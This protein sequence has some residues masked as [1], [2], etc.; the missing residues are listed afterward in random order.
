M[1]RRVAILR[2]FVINPDVLLMDEPFV[3][4]DPPTARQAQQLLWQLWQ[5]RPHTVLFVSHDLREAIMLAD[6]LVFVSTLPMRILAEIPVTIPRNQRQQEI[7]IETFRQ[8]LKL[9]YP[10]IQSLL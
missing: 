3:S 7:V 4:L 2:A 1:Q 6:Q 8:Q 5:Q 9:S 10:Q